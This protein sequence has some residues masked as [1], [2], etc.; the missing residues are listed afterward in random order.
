MASDS[1]HE[2]GARDGPRTPSSDSTASLRTPDA[3]ELA[4]DA[5]PRRRHGDRKKT[6]PP[7]PWLSRTSSLMRMPSASG[8]RAPS[9]PGQCPSAPG[10]GALKLELAT[11]PRLPSACPRTPASAPRFS[12]PGPRPLLTAAM[13]APMQPGEPETEALLGYN[14]NLHDARRA[15][16]PRA[17]SIGRTPSTP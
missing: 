17:A 6:L 11:S 16:P 7:I 15:G 13:A 3:L 14:R 9:K 2:G 1:S 12:P 8:L 5:P 4:D 10:H